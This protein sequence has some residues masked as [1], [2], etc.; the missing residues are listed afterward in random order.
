MGEFIDQAKEYVLQTQKAL[1]GDDVIDV[2]STP[3][4]AV[5]GEAIAA[6]PANPK[7]TDEKTEDEEF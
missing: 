5:D 3:V 1:Q 6:N 7:S 2:E 4:E